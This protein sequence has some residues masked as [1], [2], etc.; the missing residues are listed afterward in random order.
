MCGICGIYNLDGRPLDK[1]LL[2]R[3]NNTLVHRGPDDEG[4]FVNTGIAG[5]REQGARSK[6]H[7]VSLRG[8]KNG[9]GGKGNVGL[10]H[11]RLSIID[12]NTGHQPIFNED[13]TKVIYRDAGRP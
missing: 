6:E 5:S 2:E 9:L 12:L 7:G 8:L 11:R 4:Y 1:K 3:M 13:R 10:G